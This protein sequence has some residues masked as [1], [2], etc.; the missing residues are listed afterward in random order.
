MGRVV[1]DTLTHASRYSVLH[2]LFSRAFTFV[3]TTPLGTLPPG[4]IPLEADRLVVS[5]DQVDGRGRGGARLEAHRRY[6]DIQVTIAGTEH[7]GWR[8]L[9]DCSTPDGPFAPDR[10]VGFFADRPDTWVVVPERHFVIF[11]PEDA[12]APLAGEGPL[13]KAVI[14]VEL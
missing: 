8:P 7:I 12:H 11:F 2:P 10:D 1:I 5:I 13:R 6:I 3:A 9:A 14:K 4:R